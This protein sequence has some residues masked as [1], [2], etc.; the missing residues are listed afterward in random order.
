MS[1]FIYRINLFQSNITA[2]HSCRHNDQYWFVHNSVPPYQY[3]KSDTISYHNETRKKK[4][5]HNL[6]SLLLRP[7]NL[8]YTDDIRVKKSYDHMSLLISGCMTLEPAPT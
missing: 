3:Q 2:T 8:W 6:F 1:L 7:G 4:Q 5:S